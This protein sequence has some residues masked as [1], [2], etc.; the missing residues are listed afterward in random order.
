MVLGNLR[1]KK[2]PICDTRGDYIGRKNVIEIKNVE[3]MVELNNFFKNK[4][5][6]VKLN[7]IVCHKHLKNMKSR[8]K[9]IPCVENENSYD[10][11]NVNEIEQENENHIE[12]QHLNGYKNV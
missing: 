9:N 4:K 3:K 12:N 8:N 6:K 7:N 1:N 5:S 11:E 2:C 10:T